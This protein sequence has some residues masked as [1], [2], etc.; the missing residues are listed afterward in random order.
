MVDD[1]LIGATPLPYLTSSPQNIQGQTNQ[2]FPPEP[3]IQ[4]QMQTAQ[5]SSGFQASLV[6]HPGEVRSPQPPTSLPLLK[7]DAL[8]SN[9]SSTKTVGL[10]FERA[11]LSD[12]D[13]RSIFSIKRSVDP[14]T[15][16]KHQNAADSLGERPNEKKNIL[17]KQLLEQG[18]SIPPSLLS[19]ERRASVVSL[20]KSTTEDEDDSLSSTL[21]PAQQQQLAMIE[22]MPLTLRKESLVPQSPL[23]STVSG[24]ETL[25]PPVSEA[26]VDGE[27]GK[28]K[29]SAKKKKK[30]GCEENG[31]GLAADP[32]AESIVNIL[33]EQLRQC[34]TVTLFEP[35]KNA[36]PPKSIFIKSETDA[37]PVPVGK[38]LEDLRKPAR[39]SLLG[40]FGQYEVAR[41]GPKSRFYVGVNG[42]IEDILPW[43]IYS[44]RCLFEECIEARNVEI[45]LMMK[46]EAEIK[47]EMG[48]YS[49]LSPALSYVSTSS[50]GESRLLEPC[51]DYMFNWLD[52]CY[53]PDGPPSCEMVIYEP[54]LLPTSDPGTPNSVKENFTENPRSDITPATKSTK[55]LKESDRVNVSL[56]VTEEAARDINTFLH[57][58][59]TLLQIPVSE[60]VMSECDDYDSAVV[61]VIKEDKIQKFCRTCEIAL[62]PGNGIR[63]ALSDFPLV[64]VV[65]KGFPVEME[66][67]TAY[68]SFCGNACL[69]QF[70]I[71]NQSGLK[72]SPPATVSVDHGVDGT[73]KIEPKK[74]KRDNSPSKRLTSVQVILKS[75][76]PL[77]KRGKKTRYELWSPGLLQVKKPPPAVEPLTA[78]QILSLLDVG[79]KL[80]CDQVRDVRVC[81]FCHLIG[82]FLTDGPGRLLNIDGDHWV[83]LNCALWSSQV[84]ETL[85][86]HLMNVDVACQRG[87]RTECS[88]CKKLGA[89]LACYNPKI[90]CNQVFH[91]PCAKIGGCMFFKDKSVLCDL[92]KPREHP[93]E[94]LRALSVHRRVYVHRDEPR[95]V[96]R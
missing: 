15:S 93:E 77:L 76:A 69:M 54:T 62:S 23:L 64:S 35:D 45:P 24:N 50:Y 2:S 73:P 43:P 16:S 57:G 27:G 18:N 55:F 8:P 56:T 17:L 89:T 46:T 58:L 49:P 65:D 42:S 71:N 53:P 26:S 52:I 25:N 7:M 37:A 36:L 41:N 21:T 6:N 91:F 20:T 94:E 96:A 88:R 19:P 61:P 87:A 92:H 5:T 30:K 59:A 10:G 90:R 4:Q 48:D 1:L 31:D 12:T 66:G 78:E 9:L 47:P 83:H 95:L 79:I 29:K 51:Y 39:K 34:H 86:G 11:E 85:N 68:V 33:V 82:D 75:I 3:K 44:S 32:P 38:K 72:T 70:A 28:K 60:I 40:S 22:S 67:G 63:R 81:V 74:E 80:K 13:G 14:H 84:Y